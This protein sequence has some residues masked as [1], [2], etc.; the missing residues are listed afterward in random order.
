MD[1]RL[2]PSWNTALAS[3]LTKNYF[4]QLTTTIEADYLLQDPP[5]YP[6]AKDVFNAFSLC[7][8]SE[9]KV[10]IL[11]QDPYHGAGQAHGLAFS[12]Q[13]GVKTPPS[14]KNIYKEIQCDGGGDIPTTGNLTRWATQGVLLL[15]TTLTVLEGQPGSH[16][17]KGWETFT[18]AV[19]K[20]ISDQKAH[21]VFLLWG[22][23]ARSKAGL[24]DTEKHCVLEAAHPSPL[25]AHNGFFGCQ[26]FSLTNEYLTQHNRTPI[27]W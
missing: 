10:V 7:P 23:F 16:Q 15:N 26:H 24:I 22:N 8:L 4:I 20:T 12:V 25:S 2:E 13:D 27:N 19:I 18:D 3:E 14:L 9:V 17:K 6:P 5:V 21:V 11:G 1:I